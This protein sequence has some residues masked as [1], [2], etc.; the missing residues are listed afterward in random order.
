MRLASSVEDSEWPKTSATKLMRFESWIVT[1][2]VVALVGLALMSS[3]GLCAHLGMAAEIGGADGFIAPEFVGLAAEHDPSRFQD[4]A[5]I[6]NRQSH[7]RVLLDK[8][9]RG[10]VA[11]LRDDP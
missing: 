4:I 3:W 9:D 5:V 8:Q 1:I 2:S 7:A 11:N 10:A 6:G